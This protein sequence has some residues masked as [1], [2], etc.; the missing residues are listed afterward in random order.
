MRKAKR[1]KTGNSW[2][3]GVGSAE[4]GMG[5][6]GFNLKI[7]NRGWRVGQ[8]SQ[9]AKVDLYFQFWERPQR[10]D[11]QYKNWYKKRICF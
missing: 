3:C 1:V 4:L 7:F 2:E 10:Q 8:G 9:I 11:P 5:S 6:L